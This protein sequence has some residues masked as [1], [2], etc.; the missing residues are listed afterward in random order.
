MTVRQ[1]NVV[2]LGF[3]VGASLLKEVREDEE[4]MME[5]K[6]GREVVRSDPSLRDVVGFCEL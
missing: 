5:K 6:D 4:K 1:T 3:I 2:W